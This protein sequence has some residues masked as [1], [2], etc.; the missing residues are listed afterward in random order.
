MAAVP[1][2]FSAGVVL[3]E[4]PPLATCDACLPEAVAALNLQSSSSTNRTSDTETCSSEANTS[5]GTDSG[6]ASAFSTPIKGPSENSVTPEISDTCPDLQPEDGRRFRWP[7]TPKLTKA[8]TFNKPIHWLTQNRFH[9]LT[10]LFGKHLIEYLAKEKVD[11]AGT[12]NIS[13]KLKLLGEDEATARPCVIVLCNAS[14]SKKVKKFFRRKSVKSQYQ[15]CDPSPEMPYLEVVVWTRPPRLIASI[16]DVYLV[17][18]DCKPG[19]LPLGGTPIKVCQSG[20][21]R[22]ATL[23]GIVVVRTSLGTVSFYGMSAGHIIAQENPKDRS[24]DRDINDGVLENSDDDNGGHNEEDDDALDLENFELD[25]TFQQDHGGVA[26]NLIRGHSKANEDRDE[27]WRKIGHVSKTSRTNNLLDGSPDFDW[28]L[29]DITSFLGLNPKLLND[30]YG[31][32]QATCYQEKSLKCNRPVMAFCGMSGH[33]KGILSTTMSYLAISPSEKFVKTYDLT[34]TDGTSTFLL[35][36]DI[37]YSAN[38][39][40]RKKFYKMAT[41]GPGWWILRPMRSTG[42]W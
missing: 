14:E 34:L 31:K 5:E 19:L 27:P 41:L 1:S 24:R 40:H 26:T 37:C 6:Y 11:V 7:S 25:V 23:G 38:L 10:E 30:A 36:R 12:W 33:R 39:C 16:G 22:F 32:R 15:P 21:A 35:P 20:I 17:S 3:P 28:S 42:T 9:D 18:V 29:I 2:S 8:K 4:K 13:M